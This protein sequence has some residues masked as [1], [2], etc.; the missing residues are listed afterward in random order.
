MGRLVRDIPRRP[1]FQYVDLQKTPV[2]GLIVS[3]AHL[4]DN[5]PRYTLLGSPST[6]EVVSSIHTSR[7]V[8]PS[9]LDITSEIHIPQVVT[10]TTLSTL[11]RD[12][13]TVSSGLSSPL[14]LSTSLSVCSRVLQPHLQSFV[15]DNHEL[16][17]EI[18]PIL[19]LRSISQFKT[20]GRPPGTPNKKRSRVET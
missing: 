5:S 18:D 9:Q 11:I 1:D 13:K 17:L 6:S 16:Q 7:P 20:K 10:Q 12:S 14:S 2:L 4:E 15:E 3:R 8:S 19:E